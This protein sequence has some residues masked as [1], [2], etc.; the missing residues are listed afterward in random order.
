MLFFSL[1]TNRFT[2]LSCA[3]KIAPKL[4]T[5]GLQYNQFSLADCSGISLFHIVLQY[6]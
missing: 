5:V 3:H 2:V 1:L 6:N 4:R